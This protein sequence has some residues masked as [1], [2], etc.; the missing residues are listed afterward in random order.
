MQHATVSQITTLVP[1]LLN[2]QDAI[3]KVGF[4]PVHQREVAHYI[5]NGI[6]AIL[7]HSFAAALL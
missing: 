1:A 3:V 2:I 6:L 5:N 4:R 7:L